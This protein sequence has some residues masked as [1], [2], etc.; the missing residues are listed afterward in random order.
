M[1]ALY[2]VALISFILGGMGYI[3]VRFWFF[4]IIRY[5]KIRRRIAGAMTGYADIAV[6]DETKTQSDDRALK[7]KRQ[8]R[9]YAADL[10]ELYQNDLPHWYKILLNQRGEDPVE[11]AR[12]IMA[13]VNSRRK[14][15]IDAR[16]KSV[17]TLIRL[18]S[19][20]RR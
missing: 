7:G 16:L 12:C 14:D 5:G 2:L 18:R 6:S 1:E 10:S 3:V 20:E 8:L 11:A 4:P 15:D 19:R 17:D 9:R 13:L